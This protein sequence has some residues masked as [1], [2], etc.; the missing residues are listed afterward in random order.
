MLSTRKPQPNFQISIQ[1]LPRPIHVNAIDE[2]P[3]GQEQVTHCSQDV[4]LQVSALHHVEINFLITTPTSQ[5]LVLGLSWLQTHD[6]VISWRDKGIIRWLHSFQEKCLLVPCTPLTS[7]SIESPDSNLQ[8]NIPKQY[9]EF[10]EEFS[11][12]CTSSSLIGLCHWS[13]TWYDSSDSK[14]YPLSLPEQ[15]AMEEYINKALQQGYIR[16]SMSPASS[17]FFFVEKKGGGLRPC[18]DYR[19]LNQMTVKYQY[20]L[21]L[22]SPQLL[23]RREDTVF[24]KLDLCSAYNLI[25]IW[26]GDEW[27]QHSVLHGDI[28]NIW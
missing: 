21:P 16:P 13:V 9:N 10:T 15:Q 20:L 25:H 6:P 23:S 14:T 1:K 2:R 3:V 27:R 11:K 4:H 19:G 28:M 7:T 22:V 5:F 12:M 8:V 26:E 24:T 17:G 18:I